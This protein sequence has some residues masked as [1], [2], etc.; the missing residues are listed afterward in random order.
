MAVP[1]D[2]NVIGLKSATGGIELFE[3]FRMPVPELGDRDVLI[4]VDAAGMNPVDDKLR[5]NFGTPGPLDAPKV[6]GM[7]GCG[8]IAAVGK[9][10]TFFKV[11]DVVWTAGLLTKNGTNADYVAHDE[12]IVGLA[13][14]SISRG[15]AASVPLVFLTAWE[16]LF[17][18]LGLSEFDPALAGKTLLVLPGAGGVGS[19]VIQLASAILGLTVIATASRPESGQAC[20]NLGAKYTINHRQPLKPQIEALGLDGVDYIYN[21]YKTDVYFDQY[22]DIVKPLG[23]IVSIVETDEPMALGKLMHKRVTFVWELMFTRPLFNV[24]MERQHGILNDAA[25][26][27][28]RGLIRLPD[29]KVLPWSLQS[30]KKMHTEQ[31]SGTM[32]GKNVMSRGESTKSSWSNGAMTLYYFPAG[33]RAEVSRCIAA[34]G[35]IELI[36]GG[37]GSDLDKSSY[38]S[39]SG[40]PLL[41]H[42]A[43]KMSQSAAIENY[44]SIWAFPDLSPQQRGIDC[45]LCG[46]KE[47]V[48]AG[49]YKVVFNPAMKEDKAKQT[50]ELSQVSS[51]WYPVIE[52]RCPSTGFFNGEA[53]PTAADICVMNI[54]D[55]VMAFAACNKLGGVD[56]ATYPKMRALANRTAEYLP[57]KEYL[58]TSTTFTANPMGL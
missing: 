22:C 23:G 42:G 11:G 27:I 26:L 53:Y 15:M 57:L 14:T 29:V 54:C 12:R 40:V 24:E 33:G 6:L 46:I 37:A 19:F 1:A 49:Y 47:D 32:I 55:C 43:L 3:E 25:R 8:T 28:D 20:I 50:E 39:P 4:K 10:V 56:W 45:M 30:L 18:G 35:G 34:A 58:A 17:E 31:A 5:T 51:K 44:L 38:G 2:M 21:A 48:A 16:G 41:A 36:E 9:A 13:P 52:S 7:D